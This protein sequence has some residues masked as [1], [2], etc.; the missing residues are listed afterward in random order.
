MSNVTPDVRELRRENGQK[1]GARNYRQ[2]VHSV[3]FL[4]DSTQTYQWKLP[5]N[6]QR[7]VDAIERITESPSG[8]Y[9]LTGQFSRLTKI[10]K[11]DDLLKRTADIQNMCGEPLFLDAV[12]LTENPTA[13][14]RELHRAYWPYRV[15]GEW[16]E[17][18]R[19]DHIMKRP[20]AMPVGLSARNITAVLRITRPEIQS[21]RLFTD[22]KHMGTKMLVPCLMCNRVFKT[23]AYRYHERGKRF[24]SRTCQGKFKTE[25]GK[26]AK[27]A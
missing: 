3:K 8:V 26:D 7:I 18:P 10:G 22:V 17:L 24:C 15:H 1:N 13:L 12:I 4:D 20:G 27:A 23:D 19:I 5:H 2:H 16:F 25:F 6:V 21:T 14:E 11:A 9:L